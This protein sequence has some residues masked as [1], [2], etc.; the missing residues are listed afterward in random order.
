MRNPSQSK[1]RR[2]FFLLVSI[3][4]LLSASYIGCQPS[5]VSRVRIKLEDQP[6]DKPAV[7][8]K[9][10]QPPP[11]CPPAGLVPLQAGTPGT[12]DHKVTLTWNP[13]VP[14]NG[15]DSAAVGYCLYRSKIK[16]AAKQNPVCQECEQVNRVP[17]PPTSGLQNC[18]DDLVADSTRYYYVVTAINS[19]GSLSSASNEIPVP[20]PGARSVKPSQAGTLPLCR[21]AIQP[22]AR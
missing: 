15:P 7:A 21:T 5:N 3:I 13:S 9:P 8:T 4:V 1:A 22:Q 2:H 12:G 11:V 20:V 14:S 19:K 6:Q 17:I 16:H 18:V 10:V